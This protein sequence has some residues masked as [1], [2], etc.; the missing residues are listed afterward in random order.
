MIGDLLA[1]F[2]MTFFT[3]LVAYALV[4]GLTVASPQLVNVQNAANDEYTRHA[5]EE[6]YVEAF[7]S[8]IKDITNGYAMHESEEYEKIVK[9]MTPKHD[10]MTV[11]NHM[12]IY[13]G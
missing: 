9:P 1:V 11:G 2:A 4:V 7:N 5:L 10:A 8:N 12:H 3:T 13:F 6:A